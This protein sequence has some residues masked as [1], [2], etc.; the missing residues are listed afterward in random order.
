[1]ISDLVPYFQ[2]YFTDHDMVDVVA[3]KARLLKNAK[4]VYGERVADVLMINAFEQN[5][6]RIK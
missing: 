1:M 2:T 6:N 3:I 4:A 5:N